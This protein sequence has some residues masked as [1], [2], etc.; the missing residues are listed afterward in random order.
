MDYWFKRSDFES[1]NKRIR[2]HVLDYVGL[3]DFERLV[4]D[5]PEFQRLK[6]IRQLTCQHVY[7]SARHTR[8]EHSLGVLELTHEALRHIIENSKTPLS[9]ID[10][11]EITNE[12]AFNTQFAALIHDIGHC[13]FSHMGENELRDDD[14][15]NVREILVDELK[16]AGILNRELKAAVYTVKSI[17]RHEWLSCIIF[18]RKLYEKLF[19]PAK[20][21]RNSIDW[22]DSG[23]N[24]VSVSDKD[25]KQAA[26]RKTF[27]GEAEFVIRCILGLKYSE[28]KSGDELIKNLL[29]SL[30]NSSSFDMDKLDYIMR[31][32][33]HTAIGAPIIDIKRLFRNMCIVND[34]GEYIIAFTSK[35]VPD[36]QNII[37]ARDELYMYVYNHHTAVYTDFIYSYIFRRLTGNYEKRI[38]SGVALSGITSTASP[39]CT[40]SWDEIKKGE[41]PPDW[42][43]SVDAVVERQCSDSEVIAVMNAQRAYSKQLDEN[44][45]EE[46]KRALNLVN[47]LANRNFLKAWWKTVYEFKSFMGSYFKGR[48]LERLPKMICDGKI[49]AEVRSQIAKHVLYISKRLHETNKEVMPHAL[50]DGEFFVVERSNK[51]YRE[52]VIESFIVYLKQNEIIGATSAAGYSSHDEY[53]G[54][55]FTELLPQKEYEDMYG[56]AAFYI[57]MKPY[58]GDDTNQK[59]FEMERQNYYKEVEEIFAFV[60]KRIALFGEASFISKYIDDDEIKKNEANYYEEAYEEYLKQYHW[61]LS[62]II[63]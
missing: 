26:K 43:F 11:A 19:I 47:D 52:E 2:D 24:E 13:P 20:I 61:R 22:L 57:Y 45:D 60:G 29:I 36:I 56:T 32:S 37:D 1:R 16:A 55:R 9:N 58:A 14:K 49:G 50:S 5:T 4:V 25:I 3:S 27:A 17:S 21:A 59:N 33:F 46:I 8:F 40:G 54:K 31:D 28:S 51:F 42:L 7:A 23:D 10:P 6:D 62:S 48:E 12:Y 34:G 44:D 39:I 15:N 35:A 18:I 38:K 30:I 63:R 41:I 53:Y